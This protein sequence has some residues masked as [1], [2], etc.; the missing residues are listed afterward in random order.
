MT[1]GTYQRRRQAFALQSVR[2]RDAPPPTQEERPVAQPLARGQCPKCLKQ[3]GRG[4]HF[5]TR[6]CRG[7]QG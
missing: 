2:L 5:H 4:L 3:I 6:T 1:P 7:D